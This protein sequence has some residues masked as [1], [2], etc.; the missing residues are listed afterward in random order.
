MG[1]KL[2]PGC[3]CTEVSVMFVGPWGAA[4]SGTQEPGSQ[5]EEGKAAASQLGPDCPPARA[6]CNPT[7]SSHFKMKL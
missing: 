7:S 1:Q 3:S 6:L 4:L 5:T 2:G